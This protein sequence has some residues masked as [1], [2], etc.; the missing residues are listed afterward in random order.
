MK[1]IYATHNIF[2]LDKLHRNLRRIIRRA[3]PT[4]VPCAE[5]AVVGWNSIDNYLLIRN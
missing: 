1:T 5:A 4:K 3:L 2:D